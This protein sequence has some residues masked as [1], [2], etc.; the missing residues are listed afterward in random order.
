MLCLGG[1][2]FVDQSRLLGS[3][4]EL[5]EYKSRVTPRYV[6]DDEPPSGVSSSMLV[7]FQTS[8]VIGLAGLIY[9]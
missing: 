9:A 8:F 1:F 7:C 2:D 6:D 4:N 3:G 5:K